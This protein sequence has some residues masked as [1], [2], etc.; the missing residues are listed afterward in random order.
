MCKE[1]RGVRRNIKVPGIL[2]AA[3]IFAVLTLG[4]KARA[5]WEYT[6]GPNNALVYDL[7]WD[8]NDSDVVYA[9]TPTGVFKTT[10]GGI[11]WART[12]KGIEDAAIMCLGMAKSN[13]NVIYAGSVS[14]RDYH[15]EGGVDEDLQYFGLYKTTDGGANWTR[16]AYYPQAYYEA[17]A[18]NPNN[19]DIVLAC[20]RI[21]GN[22]V[23][24]SVD[25]GVSW[26]R[27][28]YDYDA[29]AV[30][31]APSNPS[32][33]YAS[34][35][36]T[37][38]R[39]KDGG[40]NWNEV[41]YAGGQVRS[42]AVH[43]NNPN[44]VV[45][46]NISA[47]YRGARRSADGGATWTEVLSEISITKLVFDPSDG[48]I[49]YAAS[50]GAPGGQRGGIYRSSDAGVSWGKLVYPGGKYANDYIDADDTT[51]LAVNPS[52]GREILASIY[53]YGVHGTS[54]SGA[55]WAPRR[56]GLSSLPTF[57]DC[58][59]YEVA[60]DPDDWRTRLVGAYGVWRWKDGSGWEPLDKGLAAAQGWVYAIAFCPSNPDIICMAT[61][62]SGV[63]RSTNGGDNWVNVIAGRDEFHDIAFSPSSD[64]VVY[65]AGWRWGI[66]SGVWKS[67]DRGLTWQKVY[68]N[69][70]DP[71]FS[72]AVDPTNPNR[73][74]AGGL[75]YSGETSFTVIWRTTDGGS[76]WKEVCR[77]EGH[78]PVYAIA[79]NPKNPAV[80]YGV[81][82][83]EVGVIRSTDG[84][85][86][87]TERTG[88]FIQTDLYDI[89]ISPTNPEYVYVTGGLLPVTDPRSVYF[90]NNGGNSWAPLGDGFP[91]SSCYSIA[92]ATPGEMDY[93][94]IGS[95]RYGAYIWSEFTGV[96]NVTFTAS[97]VPRGVALRWRAPSSKYVG[98]NLYREPVA[99]SPDVNLVKLNSRLITGSSPHTFL[100]DDVTAGERYRYWLEAVALSGRAERY[101]PAE[102]SAGGKRPFAFALSQNAP[103][104]CRATTTISFSLPAAGPARL[105]LFD[106]AG[107]RVS[108]PVDGT[109]KAGS[110]TLELETAALPPGVYVY[111]LTAGD[112]TAARRMVVTR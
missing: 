9:A 81:S 44:I 25:G 33:A 55:T 93:V 76:V 70:N 31:F 107:R 15:D 90:S 60:V 110:Y 87:W 30:A 97:S 18:V 8:P 1:V 66:G 19:P 84:G 50:D 69:G 16:L 36:G 96:G 37:V 48:A 92:V 88:G 63:W 95:E 14:M 7:L 6:E 11:H 85:K 43:P 54:D 49:C 56:K 61:S 64:N 3:V 58:G 29:Q 39:S 42:I 46:A 100:D 108:S 82:A 52:D 79:I 94:I 62:E 71:V 59:V 101:G 80:I 53:Y 102:A 13:S 78:E 34:A 89:A 23:Y 68:D 74:F 40:S 21:D 72:V 111:R 104:P 35:S 28:I 103:N 106:L 98:F 32:I 77:Y 105:E 83:W 10:D 27:T 99:V 17:V 51:A 57:A 109:V 112:D 47:G 12:S 26:E 2:G 65:A 45:L 67:N 75:I 22:G 41:L 24:R 73:V 5:Y 4:A 38:Y 20:I 86:T 91:L